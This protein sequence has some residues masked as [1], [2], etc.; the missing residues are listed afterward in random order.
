MGPQGFQYVAEAT[1]EAAKVA[2]NGILALLARLIQGSAPSTR[3]RRLSDSVSYTARYYEPL[4][5]RLDPVRGEP[6]EAGGRLPSGP[7]G[8][9]FTH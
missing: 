3:H 2:V 6:Q 5:F 7:G 9:T 8:R 4:P 1:L